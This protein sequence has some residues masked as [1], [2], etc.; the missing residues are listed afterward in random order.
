MKK[1]RLYVGAQH[2]KCTSSQGEWDGTWDDSYEY[3]I[4]DEEGLEVAGMDGFLTIDRAR[5]AGD[6]KLNELRSL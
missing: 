3:I 1:F 5:E 6:K 4:Y 2:H